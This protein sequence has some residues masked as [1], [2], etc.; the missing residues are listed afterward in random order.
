MTRGYPLIHLFLMLDVARK[1]LIVMHE[2]RQY[3]SADRKTFIKSVV[4][5]LELENIK[6]QFPERSLN[7]KVLFHLIDLSKNSSLGATG[8]GHKA[9]VQKVR[10]YRGDC[11]KCRKSM[12][13]RC[14]ECYDY[15]CGDP[16]IQI[17]LCRACDNHLISQLFIP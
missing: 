17:V 3:S 11:G 1:F 13:Y 14:S 6:M 10:K 9:L 8:D 7:C 5:F 2:S 4:D 12:R 16:R 15:I